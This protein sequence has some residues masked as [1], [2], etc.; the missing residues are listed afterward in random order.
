MAFTRLTSRERDSELPVHGLRDR[1]RQGPAEDLDSPFTGGGKGRLGGPTVITVP[2]DA[3]GVEHQQMGGAPFGDEPAD[4]R[5]EPAQRN[6]GEPVIRTG[7]QFHA[8]HAQFP[9][10]AGQFVRPHRA[11]V[12]GAGEQG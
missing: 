5:G 7:G 2:G 12:A 10:G 1:P 11:Q 8:F 6:S 9:C 3:G 4:P